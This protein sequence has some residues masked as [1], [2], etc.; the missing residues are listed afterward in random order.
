MKMVQLCGNFFVFSNFKLGECVF[1]INGG[2]L[3]LDDVYSYKMP[4]ILIHW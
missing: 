4:L 2:V 3:C 1:V